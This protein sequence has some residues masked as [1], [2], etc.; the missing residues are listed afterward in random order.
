MDVEEFHLPKRLLRVVAWSRLRRDQLDLDLKPSKSDGRISLL[1]H[2]YIPNET[3]LW[4]QIVP[5]HGIR[6]RIPRHEMW[7]DKLVAELHGRLYDLSLR[8]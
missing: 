8:K 3:T 5:A 2:A 1:G 6:L 4:G 7:L